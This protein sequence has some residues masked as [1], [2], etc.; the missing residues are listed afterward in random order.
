MGLFHKWF[1]GDPFLDRSF[2]RQ[3]RLS[4]PGETAPPYT[5]GNAPDSSYYAQRGYNASHGL[6]GMLGVGLDETNFRHGGALDAQR[7]GDNASP[8]Y[9]NYAFGAYNGGAGLSLEHTLALANAYAYLAAEYNPKTVMDKTY[10]YTPAENVTNITRGY[11]D[12]RNNM[13]WRRST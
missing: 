5:A 7:K 10:T 11:N 3:P 12:Q 1:S 9:A 2:H 4:P 6:W 13:L 8:G